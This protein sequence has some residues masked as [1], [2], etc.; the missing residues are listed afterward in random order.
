MW[1]LYRKP[2]QDVILSLRTM[3]EDSND[4]D[5]VVPILQDLIEPPDMVNVDRSFQLLYNCKFFL[6]HLV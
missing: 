2:L 5:G 3:L 1:F 4:F 6:I